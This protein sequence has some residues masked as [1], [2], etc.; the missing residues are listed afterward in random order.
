[1]AINERAKEEHT[2]YLAHAE[3]VTSFDLV[4]KDD[5]IAVANADDTCN[6]NKP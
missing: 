5:V 1:M 4:F 2:T 6:T 3:H